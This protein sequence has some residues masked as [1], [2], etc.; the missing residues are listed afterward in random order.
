MS[1]AVPVGE[2]TGK[3]D[4]IDLSVIICTVDRMEM[5][6][7]AIASIQ[8]QDNRRELAM[9]VVVVDNHPRA[10][11][12]EWVAELANAST[13]PIV[14]RHAVPA[15]ISAAR[16]AGIEA[17]R[18]RLLAFIDDDETA[19]PNWSDDM[20]DTLE[21]Y[22]AM[23]VSGPMVPIF[24]GGE[25]PAWDPEGSCYVRCGGTSA[26]S[27]GAVMRW[28]STCNMLFRR[29]ILDHTGLFDLEFGKSGGE[30]QGFTLRARYAG[31]KMVWCE[32]AAVVEFTPE[33]RKRHTYMLRRHYVSTQAYMRVRWAR[34]P[35][36][37][38][39]MLRAMTT[40]LIQ[41]LCYALPY[42]AFRLAPAPCY[43]KWAL[44]FVIG[45]GKVTWFRYGADS[46]W[47]KPA[48][49]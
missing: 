14:Y 49:S 26:R 6:K 40:G 23:L 20:V 19:V 47:V 28:A 2:A 44:Q 16:N 33:E 24:S 1:G 29:E 43:R 4:S 22:D 30:D 39:F 11:A 8:R 21:N 25:P 34:H 42:L 17:S 31:A 37:M 13:L 15:N 48:R 46:F 18:G 32:S 7:E 38:V 36:K 35:A 5:A 27:T 3:M 10:A 12:R 41:V 9:E 45:A